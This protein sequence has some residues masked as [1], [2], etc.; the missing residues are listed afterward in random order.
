MERSPKSSKS[1][2]T[3]TL[4]ANEASISYTTESLVDFDI[5]LT[6]RLV[7]RKF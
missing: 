3:T 5:E 1:T 2:I 4:T 6:S 7:K